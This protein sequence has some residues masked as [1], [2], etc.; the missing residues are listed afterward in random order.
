MISILERIPR[1]ENSSFR[2]LEDPKLHDFYY[3][4]FHPEIE[5][6]YIEGVDGQRHI[7]SHYSPYC[8]GD[9]ALIGSYIPHLNFDY[10]VKGDYYKMVLQMDASFLAPHSAALPEL[11]SIRSLLQDANHGV[12]FSKKV[13]E[14][15]G[16]MMKDLSLYSGVGLLQYV[17]KICDVLATDGGRRLLH[18]LPYQNAFYE[19][20]QEKFKRVIQYIEEHYSR[21]LSLREVAKISNYSEAAFCRYFKKMTRLSF[22]TFVNNYRI[23]I[24]KRLLREGASVTEVAFSCGFE[25]VSYFN[26]TFKKVTGINPSK[27]G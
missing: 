16:E 22:T 21:K 5:L 25:G 18:K 8:D 4:Y 20:Q 17:L 10:G 9:L 1:K 14:S 7:G 19:K 27:F 13:K 2:I 11:R 6:V 24:A 3:W 26:R 15:V 12:V 23:D